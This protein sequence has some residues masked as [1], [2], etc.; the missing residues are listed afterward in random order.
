MKKK[1]IQCNQV[2]NQDKKVYKWKE[3]NKVV[4]QLEEKIFVNNNKKIIKKKIRNKNIKKFKK[5]KKKKKVKIIVIGNI[6]M[7][8]LNYLQK[9]EKEIK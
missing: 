5:Q 9:I 3:E 2:G 1:K 6:Y 7:V 4:D 8:H